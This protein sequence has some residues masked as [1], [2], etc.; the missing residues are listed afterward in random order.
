MKVEECKNIIPFKKL[1]QNKVV[2][3]KA[4]GNLFYLM[5]QI[6]QHK[7][8][9]SFIKK[10]MLVICDIC[11]CLINNELFYFDLKPENIL[12]RLADSDKIEIFLGDLGSFEFET[13]SSMN[14]Y[15]RFYV[16]SII[17]PD[18]GYTAYNA[19]DGEK[20]MVYI[21][22][23]I[24]T[25]CLYPKLMSLEINHEYYIYAQLMNELLKHNK[26]SKLLPFIEKYL[27]PELTSN[28]TIT[29]FMRDLNS[30]SL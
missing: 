10:T 11:K 2:M 21:L 5:K 19:L 20:K 23:V 25:E 8:Y 12:Y 29:N 22:A 27:T 24:F 17:P 9:K 4:D 15:P 14:G 7:D 13:D 30:L 3:L 6:F 16:T 18:D 1:G 26:N 28:H